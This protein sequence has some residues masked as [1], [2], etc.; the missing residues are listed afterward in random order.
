M[1]APARAEPTQEELHATWLTCRR[2]TWPETFEEAMADPLLSR[3][4]RLTW[5]HPPRT[6]A[7]QP[8]VR[9]TVGIANSIHRPQI[10][11]RGPA[12]LDRKRAAAG[13]RDDD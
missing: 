2:S 4:V 7:Q 12:V 10:F 9:R 3:L 13:E 5:A 11:P 1:A 8:A 6:Q